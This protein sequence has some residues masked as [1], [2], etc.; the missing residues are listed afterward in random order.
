MLAAVAFSIRSAPRIGRVEIGVRRLTSMDTGTRTPSSTIA[1][2]AC[3][4]TSDS[5]MALLIAR[6]RISSD[7]RWRLF[8][9][10]IRISRLT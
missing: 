6:R 5:M 7:L 1:A 4:T 10:I 9:A 3:P 8:K 2:S